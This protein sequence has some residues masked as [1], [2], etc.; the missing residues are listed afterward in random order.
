MPN[1]FHFLLR[2]EVDNGISLFMQKLST[3]YV[4]F[5]NKSHQRTGALFEGRFKAKHVDKNTYLKYLI[6]YIH[7]N[8][9]KLID[10]NWKDYGIR[11]LKAAKKFI[12]AYE[13]SS[14]PDYIGTDRIEDI[15]LNRKVLPNYFGN[16]HFKDFV[17]DWLTIKDKGQTFTKV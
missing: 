1:H 15:I 12:E 3:G 14:Y 8:P 9:I 7:L 10:P 6:A 16:L 5:F 11:D 13:H 17:E 2:E 4:M